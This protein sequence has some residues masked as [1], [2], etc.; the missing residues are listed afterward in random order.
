MALAYGDEMRFGIE[1]AELGV[2]SE[3]RY[4]A[5]FTDE[6]K[7]KSHKRESPSTARTAVLRL[8]APEKPSYWN[9][10]DPKLEIEIR[11]L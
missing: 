4:D 9:Q 7:A 11:P 2:Y 1:P 10:L 8:V 5:Y 6:Y 3:G